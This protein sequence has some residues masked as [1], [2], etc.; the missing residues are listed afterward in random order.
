[1]IIFDGDSGGALAGVDPRLRV[2]A[3]LSLAVVLY[4]V[5]SLAAPAA[6]LVVAVAVA[7]IARVPLSRTL[8]RLAA[9]NLFLL[10]LAVMIPLSTAGEPLAVWGPLAWSREGF[11]RAGRIAAQ[12]N[13]VMLS[14]FALL[15]TMD[16]IRLGVGLRGLGAPAR[17]VELFFF[18]VRYIEVIH[19]EYHRLADALSVRCYTPRL[20]RHTLTT[21]GYVV[22]QLL[23]RSLDRAERIL[24]AMRCRGFD[25]RFHLLA[26]PAAGRGDVTFAACWAAALMLVGWLGWRW[27]TP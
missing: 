14:A 23:L 2:A 10:V 18:L 20:D 19:Q 9:L 15:A 25:G 11:A 5:P 1:M 16:P 22:G 12:A 7:L 17:L 27:A 3:V 21:L 8:R 13:A 26:A 24:A 6:A 4:A